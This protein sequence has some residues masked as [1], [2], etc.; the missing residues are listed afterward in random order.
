MPL[1]ARDG[2]H[3]ARQHLRLRQSLA[4]GA[5]AMG[6]PGFLALRA[7]GYSESGLTPAGRAL[8]SGGCCPVV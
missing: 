4:A 3:G 5:G 6:I 7:A 8:D 2:R 1:R